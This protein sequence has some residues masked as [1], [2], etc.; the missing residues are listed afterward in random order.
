V[1][2]PWCGGFHNVSIGADGRNVLHADVRSWFLP[3]AIGQVVTAPRAP[4][5]ASRDRVSVVKP[6]LVQELTP[7]L[8]TPPSHDGVA[9]SA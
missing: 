5:S 1:S 9:L 7:A 8:L 3:T 6:V 4:I 2:L